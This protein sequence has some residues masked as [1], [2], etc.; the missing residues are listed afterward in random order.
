MILLLFSLKLY[1]V[2]HLKSFAD[3]VKVFLAVIISI[4][5]YYMPLFSKISHRAY[6]KSI[7]H[8]W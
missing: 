6:A 8:S 2:E 3:G 7:I 4:L 1:V 5:S